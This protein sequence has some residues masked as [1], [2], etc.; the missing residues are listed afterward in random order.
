LPDSLLQPA[1]LDAQ[2]RKEGRYVI[3]PFLG[4]GAMSDVYEAWDIVLARPVALKILQHLEPAAMIRFMH[5]A[6][7]HA[8]LDSPNI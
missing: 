2:G 8:R 3:G 4:H 1:W 5:E 6:Q 7:L